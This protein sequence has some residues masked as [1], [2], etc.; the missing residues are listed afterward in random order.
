MA[1]TFEKMQALSAELRD[2][3]AADMSPE[4][5]PLVELVQIGA[6]LG[7]DVFSWLIPSDPAEADVFIDQL[8][9]LLFRVRGDDLP[10]FDPDL[11]G[12]AA[13][14]GDAASS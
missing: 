6:G 1:T 9:A 4:T 11:Y 13:L 14:N 7:L 8:L 3:A 12:E 5:R 2:T 10:P